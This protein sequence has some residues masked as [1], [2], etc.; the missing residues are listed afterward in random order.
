MYDPNFVSFELRKE[1]VGFRFLVRGPRKAYKGV[2]PDQ[3]FVKPR[4][5]TP[6][7][8]VN[9]PIDELGMAWTA[10]QKAA[11]ID[12]L[13]A[14][15]VPAP[16]LTERI[17]VDPE[18]CGARPCIRGLRIRVSDVLDMLA[19]GM[20]ADDI[21]RDYPYLERED[22]AACLRFAAHWLNHPVLRAS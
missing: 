21:L 2:V 17:T 13:D 3:Y 15:P 12:K 8:E 22:I 11:A 7:I 14:K 4:G 9:R 5:D 6:R 10:I 19:A 16:D 1:Q 20:T 18:L